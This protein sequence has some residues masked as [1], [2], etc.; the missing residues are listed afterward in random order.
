M[1]RIFFISLFSLCNLVLFGQSTFKQEPFI[2]KGQLKDC[3]EKF[4]ILYF[5]N[6]AG[7][8]LIVFD[9]YFNSEP[10]PDID[11]ADPQTLVL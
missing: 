10:G 2:L 3:P 1:S 8:S 5:D 4:L 11:S 6:N 9:A 7:S